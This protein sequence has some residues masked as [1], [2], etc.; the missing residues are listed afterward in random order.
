M[1]MRNMNW[2]RFFAIL[3]GSLSAVFYFII[4][5]FVSMFWESVFTLVN[6]GQF[7][8]LQI[9]NRRGKFSD[10]EEMFIKTCLSGVERSQARRLLKIG[11]WTEVHEDEVLIKEDT[12]PEYLKFIVAGEAQVIRRNQRVGQ[13]SAGDFIGEMSFLTGEAAS[14]TVTS[15][16]VLRYL[17]F[18]Q[19]RL[20]AHLGK[21]PQIRQAL[22]A[23]FNRNLVTKLTNTNTGL[24]IVD[25]EVA[26]T[27][28]SQ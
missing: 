14:A 19:S 2:L 7:I 20:R 23:S 11:A 16:S 3:A 25:A 18:D 22:E 28:D 13:V 21:A 5:D 12:K 9:E 17:S 15:S 1:M 10:D 24:S 26:P 27:R 6:L 8:I 4:R